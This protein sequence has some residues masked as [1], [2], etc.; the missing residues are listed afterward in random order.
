MQSDA[1]V[2]AALDA[3][4]KARRAFLSAV[5]TAADEIE[6]RLR[7]SRDKGRDSAGRIAQELGAFA[8]G[9]IDPGKLAA[10]EPQSSEPHPT[11]FEALERA[12]GVLRE[13]A[14]LTEEDFVV[15][16]MS[17]ERMSRVLVD[18]LSFLGR[19]F[20]AAELAALARAGRAATIDIDRRLEN[21][22]P[23]EWS[24]REREIAPPVVVVTK[25]SALRVGALGDWL[26]GNQKIVFVVEGPC[27]AAPLAPLLI[28]G[29][30]VAQV[31]D[32]DANS[33]ADATSAF[34]RFEG[35]AVCAFVP[36]GAVAF[37]FDPRKGLEVG[38][39][40]E[41]VSPRPIGP[42]TAW[43]QEQDLM[44][45][46]RMAGRGG[47]LNADP[48]P[49]ANGKGDADAVQPA[50]RLAAWLLNQADLAQPG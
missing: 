7:S 36:D 23:D 34:E 48:A 50:D 18:K 9:L 15:R 28:S 27:P 13:I 2:Q 26:E 41:D 30:W 47:S 19:A 12:A 32:V 42:I 37:S 21:Y 3:T 31:T 16:V 35:P 33:D 4:K 17:G 44:A 8:A 11:A 25:G 22:H 43:K 5:R 38:S 10:L 49:S 39:E 20:G 6:G 45:L 29:A 14:R 40:P 1:R 24:G 46:D